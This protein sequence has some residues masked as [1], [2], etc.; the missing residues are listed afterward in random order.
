MTNIIY[1]ITPLEILW[2][3]LG[4]VALV[5]NVRTLGYA[6]G[7]GRYLRAHALNGAR[8]TIVHWMLTEESVAVT[9]DLV[10]IA[11]GVGAMLPDGTIPQFG[12]WVA[13]GLV[14]IAGSNSLMALV[15]MRVRL[16]LYGLVRV[17]GVGKGE[18]R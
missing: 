15:R 11:I 10:V 8:R 2:T 12:Y 18:V 14:Y 17:H 5:Y 7:D 6:I 13:L 9:K 16:R 4:I 1:S 3:A